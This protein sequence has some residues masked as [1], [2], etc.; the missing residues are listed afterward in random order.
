MA[1]AEWAK[2]K[3]RQPLNQLKSAKA[4]L[5]RFNK[6]L[7][8]YLTIFPIPKGCHQLPERSFSYNDKQYPIC[9]RCTGVAIGQMLGIIST[10]SILLFLIKVPLYFV[11]AAAIILSIPMGVDWGIQYFF[12]IYSTNTRR[13]ISGVLCGIGFGALYTTILFLMIKFVA[14]LF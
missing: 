2:G 10:I 9:A 3:Q 6:I 7:Y 13:I 5:T 1:F 12:K 4:V 11:V 14:S 8:T